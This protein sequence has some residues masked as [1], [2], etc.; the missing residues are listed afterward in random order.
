MQVMGE[1]VLAEFKLPIDGFITFQPLH[2]DVKFGESRLF[3]SLCLEQPIA[4]SVDMMCY[5]ALNYI[6]IDKQPSNVK[7]ISVIM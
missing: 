5:V 6:R 3:M 7:K 2:L 1:D 4:S